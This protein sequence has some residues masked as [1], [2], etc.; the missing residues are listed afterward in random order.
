MKAFLTKL[1]TFSL[2]LSLYMISVSLINAALCSRQKIPIKA[3]R[4]LIAGDSHA[5]KGIDPSMFADAH[6]IAQNS[7]PVAITFWK[8]RKIFEEMKPD[9]LILAF[10][11][12][13][14]S[15]FNDFKFSDKKWAP[16]MFKRT[17][18]IADLK[19][20]SN[21]DIPVDYFSYYSTVWKNISLYPKLDHINYIGKY[22]N[23][24]SDNVSDWEDIINRHYYWNDSIPNVSE[25]SIQYLDSIITLCSD[26]G[27]IPVLTSHPVYKK[28]L[29][30]IPEAIMS[31]YESI[32]N[33]QEQPV[34]VYNRSK[35]E[36]YPDS[37]YFNSDHLNQYGAEQ[38]SKEL[39][40]F[41]E[42][43]NFE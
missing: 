9:T 23:E 35:A 18:P 43:P 41:L 15:Q 19:N 12:H 33:Q 5:K 27:V 16:E 36:A 38:F 30:N 22:S 37:L 2:L 25:T 31:R 20:L 26:K 34:I 4:I 13:N 7:E 28:Y 42:K 6:N 3:K 21:K 14:I 17:Y 39:I 10:A 8:L 29:I 24:K 1:I 11:P 40:Q 32:L